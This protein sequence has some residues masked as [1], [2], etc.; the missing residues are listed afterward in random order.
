MSRPIHRRID[1]WI[2]SW[3]LDSSDLLD[4]L[5]GEKQELVPRRRQALRW[6]CCQKRFGGLSLGKLDDRCLSKERKFWRVTDDERARCPE[7]FIVPHPSVLVCRISPGTRDHKS[8]NTSQ[9]STT[10]CNARHRILNFF[11]FF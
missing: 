3:L 1:C 10:S 8:P 2:Q 11:D 5:A 6:D 9:G 4:C 7:F